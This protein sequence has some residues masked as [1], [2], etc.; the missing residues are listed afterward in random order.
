MRDHWEQ[1]WWK[2][3]IHRF[4][5]P[6]KCQ[7]GQR[8]PL[9]MPEVTAGNQNWAAKREWPGKSQEWA[10]AAR[11]LWATGK[12]MGWQGSCE[13]CFQQRRHQKLWKPI[14]K[15][16]KRHMSVNTHQH[17]PGIL[18]P[19]QT[20][21]NC[22][23]ELQYYL[24]WNTTSEMRLQKASVSSMTSSHWCYWLP[25]ID[26]TEECNGA[27]GGDRLRSYSAECEGPLHWWSWL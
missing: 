27:G 20:G 6:R 10:R 9:G 22:E 7:W 11:K 21:L 13:H 23:D 17:Q 8:K 15:V 26:Y 24:P 16:L 25:A 18:Y 19:A 4:K 1:N 12:C 2:T 3:S 14:L 5:A